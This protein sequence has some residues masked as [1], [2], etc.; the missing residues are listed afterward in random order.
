[1]DPMADHYRY[2]LSHGRYRAVPAWFHNRP[3]PHPQNLFW[4]EAFWELNSE[5]PMGMGVA[6]IPGSAIRAYIRDRGFDEET[7]G[8]L[9]RLVRKMDAVFMKLIV[10][11]PVVE[12]DNAD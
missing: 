2:L 10:K 4:W 1:M 8:T 7:A 9:V 3:A 12:G 5:R 11:R 6:P